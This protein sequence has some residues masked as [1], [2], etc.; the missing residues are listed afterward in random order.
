ML[1]KI[2]CYGAKFPHGQ[3]LESLDPALS[4]YNRPKN[5]NFWSGCVASSKGY[6]LLL[7]EQVRRGSSSIL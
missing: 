6:G 5:N 1:S 4:W 7:I 2:I 3:N